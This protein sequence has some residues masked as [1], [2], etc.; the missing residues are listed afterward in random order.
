MGTRYPHLLTLATDP[1]V[2]DSG[3]EIRVADGL[4]PIP[5]S[6]SATG[7]RRGNPTPAQQGSRCEGHWW[8]APL[9]DAIPALPDRGDSKA[10]WRSVFASRSHPEQ[11][12]LRR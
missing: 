3:R 10:A 5:T 9:G 4:E 8:Q 7:I 6:G 2:G 1:M 11:N 12:P